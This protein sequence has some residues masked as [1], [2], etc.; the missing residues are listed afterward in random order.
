MKKLTIT[1]WF[2]GALLAACGG[3][4]SDPTAVT[5]QVSQASQPSQVSQAN[6]SAPPAATNNST[7]LISTFIANAD[8]ADRA[9]VAA[10]FA[11]LRGGM[12]Q[13]SDG[14]G[15]LGELSGLIDPTVQ[16]FLD[17]V[18]NYVTNLKMTTPITVSD[19]VGLL[20][21]QEQMDLD[22]ANSAA[23]TEFG[24]NGCMGQLPQQVQE[25]EAITTPTITNLYAN[26]I[27]QIEAL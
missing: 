16:K 12:R 9:S 22:W 8:G 2:I 17:N 14:C 7:A 1:A 18:V 15:A 23:Q 25:I 26:A 13:Y 24:P 6:P 19:V 4:G 3:G 5:P 21:Q 20:Q 10:N 11:A 27:A